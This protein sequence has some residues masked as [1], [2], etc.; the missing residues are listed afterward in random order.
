MNDDQPPFRW[1]DFGAAIAIVA[2]SIGAD[3][4]RDY[5]RAFEAEVLKRMGVQR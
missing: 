4:M 5:A 3:Q 1:R 2:V